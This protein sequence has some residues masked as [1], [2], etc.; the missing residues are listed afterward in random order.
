MDFEPSWEYQRLTVVFQ[1]IGE[2]VV[3]KTEKVVM[4]KVV[5]P[6]EQ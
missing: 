1:V 2:E 6:G 3:I 5:T 4:L